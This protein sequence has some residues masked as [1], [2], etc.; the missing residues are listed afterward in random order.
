MKTVLALGLASG[1]LAGVAAA[2]GETAPA[3]ATLTASPTPTPNLEA[4]ILRARLGAATEHE[5][6]LR[7]WT[8]TILGLGIAIILLI[9]GGAWWQ[10]REIHERDV[11]RIERDVDERQKTWAK[12]QDARIDSIVDAQV[13]NGKEVKALLETL[14]EMRSKLQLLHVEMQSEKL[15]S[16]L[17]EVHALGPKDS[18]LRR[19]TLALGAAINI[20]VGSEDDLAE[21]RVLLEMRE[22]QALL[23]LETDE[24]PPDT[25][26][27]ILKFLR[28]LSNDPSER[29]QVEAAH[30]KEALRRGQVSGSGPP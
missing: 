8:Q 15:Q 6:Q 5:Q 7:S 16:R 19:R 24:I 23:E 13:A 11:A 14:G 20:H 21:E 3:R 29:V 22:I 12:K 25:R 18:P 9:A 1:L 4:E 30:L 27:P 26:N 17:T 28:L 2:Q 10:N